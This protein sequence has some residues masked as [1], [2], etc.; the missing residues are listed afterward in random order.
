MSPSDVQLVVVPGPQLDQV[1]RH[2]QVDVVAVGAWEAPFAGRIEAEGGVR[3]LFTDY[4]VLG[5][6]VVGSDV[7]KKSFIEQHPQVVRDLVTASAKA[8]DWADSHLEQQGRS[9][10][11][12]SKSAAIIQT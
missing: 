10:P 8:V 6:M 5:P 2:K 7:M 3:V 1:L 11:K 9:S 12:S 4:D